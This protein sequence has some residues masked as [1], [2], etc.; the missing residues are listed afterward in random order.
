MPMETL[1]EV[2]MSE[3]LLVLVDYAW[4]LPLVFLLIGGGL[5]LLFVSKFLPLRGTLRS[6]KLITGNYHNPGDDKDS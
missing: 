5:Y 1:W 4:G 2:S 6:I 3:F